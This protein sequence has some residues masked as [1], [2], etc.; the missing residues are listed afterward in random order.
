MY[1]IRVE[2]RGTRYWVLLKESLENGNVE[3]IDEFLT[4]H[5]ALKYISKR[6]LMSH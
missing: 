6:N 5:D 3:V 2:K 4:K 1:K